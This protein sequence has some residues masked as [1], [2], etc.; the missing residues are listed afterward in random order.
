MIFSKLH[1]FLFIKGRKVAGTS[2]E[3]ALSKICGPDDIL[4]PIT[5]IDEQ[6]RLSL[7]YRPAQN[8]GADAG[9]LQSYLAALRAANSTTLAALKPPKGQFS[10]HTTL[11]EAHQALGDELQG[12]RILAIVRSPYQIVLSR[13]NHRL[14]FKHYKATG[15]AMKATL[16]AL[17][18]ELP[19][20]LDSLTAKSYP[21]NA[22]HYAISSDANLAAI[23]YLRFE[24][25]QDELDQLLRSLSIHEPITLPHLKK[26]QNLQD[27]AILEI[28][29]PEQLA[30]INHYFEDE[31]KLFGYTQLTA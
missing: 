4:T 17:R 11:Q 12:I 13:L 14:A 30:A 23:E 21:T 1:R 16:S 6:T 27:A 31:F 3:V 18:D 20:F 29:T 2:F 10:N 8:Y 26:G 7:Q 22:S 15:Q 5:P 25:L 19:A 9:K 24:H 28:A